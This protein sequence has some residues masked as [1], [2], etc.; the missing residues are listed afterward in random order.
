MTLGVIPSPFSHF[1]IFPQFVFFSI[2]FAARGTHDNVE[3]VQVSV[4][5]EC[6]EKLHSISF[7]GGKHVE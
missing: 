7:V 5:Q 2:L 4:M 1:A 6:R 3:T